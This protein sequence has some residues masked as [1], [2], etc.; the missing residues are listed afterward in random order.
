MDLTPYMNATPHT[1]LI[2][3]PVPRTFRLFRSL[4]LR[5]LVVLDRQNAVKGIITREDLTPNH[6]RA[7]LE[8][9][10]ESSKHQIQSYFRCG[11]SRTELF[12][13]TEKTML[14][15]VDNA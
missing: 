11:N 2:Q 15:L 7:C 5:H 6:L 10:S 1:V 3:S 4:G 8:G 14:H 9:L 12:E 13:Q